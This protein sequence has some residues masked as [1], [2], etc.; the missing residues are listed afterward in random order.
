MENV[1]ELHQ[2]M[3]DGSFDQIIETLRH[4]GMEENVDGRTNAVIGRNNCGCVQKIDKTILDHNGQ[5]QTD[6]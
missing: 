6:A 1:P 3:G 2:N 5:H 4:N